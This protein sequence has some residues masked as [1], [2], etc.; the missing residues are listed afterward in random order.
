[1]GKRVAPTQPAPRISKKQQIGHQ[2]NSQ[3]NILKPKVYIINSLDFKTV[4][5]DLTGNGSSSSTISSLSPPPPVDVMPAVVVS[6]EWA[7]VIQIDD[8]HDSLDHSLDCSHDLSLDN[9]IMSFDY[10]NCSSEELG[11]QWQEDCLRDQVNEIQLRN[12]E[13]WLLDFDSPTCITGEP[14]MHMNTYGY[15]YNLSTIM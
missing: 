9:S 1:M 2:L 8:D 15:D 12:L 10:S 3:I 13:S 11:L 4:V 6:P 5:Q 7:H 14:Y